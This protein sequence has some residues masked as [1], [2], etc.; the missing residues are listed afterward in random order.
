M[1]LELREL[2]MD[3][4]DYTK[5]FFDLLEPVYRKLERFALAISRDEHQAKDIVSETVL[6][7]HAGFSKLRNKQAFLSFLF[8]IARRAVVNEFRK[9]RPDRFDYEIEPDNFAK[10]SML[11]D[12]RTDITL[13]R[14][15][16]NKLKTKDREAI[17]LYEISGFSVKELADI[18]NCSLTAAKVRLFRARKK[19]AGILGVPDIKKNETITLQAGAGGK[20]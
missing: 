17:V 6:T 9:N 10:D 12:V 7:A 20:I 15:A 11:P 16:I 8:T 18:Q 14:E 19:L 1:Y 4:P 3:N 5:Q 13:L 2:K